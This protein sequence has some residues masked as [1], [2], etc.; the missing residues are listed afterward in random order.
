MKIQ[1]KLFEMAEKK[2][3]DNPLLIPLVDFSERKEEND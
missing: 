2:G 3:I 1:E